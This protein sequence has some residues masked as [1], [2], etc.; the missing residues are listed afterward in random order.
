MPNG[1]SMKT[2][3]RMRPISGPTS[4]ASVR[5]PGDLVLRDVAQVVGHEHRAGEEADADAAEPR[6][7][8]D[9]ERLHVR[10]PSGRDDPEEDEHEQ[11]AEAVVAVGA[12]AAR[13]EPGGDDRDGAD[14]EQPPLPGDDDERE[15]GERGE[16]EEAE[17]D[18]EHVPRLRDARTGEARR[19][20]PVVVGAAHPVGVVVGV[21]HADLQRERDHEREQGASR[22]ATGRRRWPR[23]PLPCRARPVR[24]RAGGC[25][26]VHPR[27]SRPRSPASRPSRTASPAAARAGLPDLPYVARLLASSGLMRW[28]FGRATT[29]C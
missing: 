18:G 5:L 2:T 1:T 8:V 14:G 20:D 17:R 26:G 16:R 12:L 13:V 22:D 9:R 7:E 27:P 10:R 23:R 25:A 3:N 4:T 15:S 11:L 21:V 19:A 24:S 6:L 28:G 29:P